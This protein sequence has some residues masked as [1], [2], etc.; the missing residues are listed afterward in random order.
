[1][2]DSSTSSTVDSDEATIENLR[3]YATV[4]ES[5]SLLNQGGSPVL[6]KC[7]RGP[8]RPQGQ[9][10]DDQDSTNESAKQERKR[11]PPQSDFS[12]S[13]AAVYSFQNGQHSGEASLQELVEGLDS[14]DVSKECRVFSVAENEWVSLK[15]V[16]DQEELAESE[17]ISSEIN[18]TACKRQKKAPRLVSQWGNGEVYK[19]PTPEPLQSTAA[20]NG[21]SK[22]RSK[23]TCPPGKL[24]RPITKAIMQWSMIEEGDKLLLGLSGGKDSISLL[25]YVP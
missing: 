13:T 1:M 19:I 10:G 21:I 3:W 18:Q 4:Q 25:Q 6:E 14:G 11:F 23:H 5:A 17:T 15:S 20:V 24:M 9:A 2:S 12:R 22:K 7:T 16:L 8:L